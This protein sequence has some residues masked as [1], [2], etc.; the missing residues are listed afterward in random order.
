MCAKSFSFICRKWEADTVFSN[1]KRPCVRGSVL[2]Y[3][4]R[5]DIYVYCYTEFTK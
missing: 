5:R 4:F 2:E 1:F 3:Q